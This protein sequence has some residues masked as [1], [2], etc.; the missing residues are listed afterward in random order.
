M[1]VDGCEGDE[2]ILVSSS[3]LKLLLMCFRG[4]IPAL[5]Q[6]TKG[7]V[8]IAKYNTDHEYEC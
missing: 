2:V 5:F 7:Y 6:H 1:G 4:K 8:K 3:A